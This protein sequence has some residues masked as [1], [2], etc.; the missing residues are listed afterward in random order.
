MADILDR[1]TEPQGKRAGRLGQ[2]FPGGEKAMGVIGEH[3]ERLA[4][5]L[6]QFS[7]SKD[8]VQGKSVLRQYVQWLRKIQALGTK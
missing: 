8:R 7:A 1:V 5:H 2:V 4:A 3:R 6:T